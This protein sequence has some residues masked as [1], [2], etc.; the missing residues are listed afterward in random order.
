MLT[1][2]VVGSFPF[3][4]YD[5]PLSHFNDAIAWAKADAIGCVDQINMGPLIAMVVDIV[6]DLAEE[7][8]LRLQHAVGFSQERRIRV[9]E[10]V[11]V[12]LRRSKDQTEADVEIL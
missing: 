12:L 4:V 9:G 11:P 5:R 2:R 10:T 1:A 3:G 8:P 7:N 6:T